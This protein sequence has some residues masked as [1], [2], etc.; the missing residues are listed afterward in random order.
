[1]ASSSWVRQ[2]ATAAI[3]RSLIRP[4][5]GRPT[6]GPKARRR[7]TF[8]AYRQRIP[9]V[10]GALRMSVVA[11]AARRRA[12]RR[13]VVAIWKP[14]SA[15]WSSCRP[16]W[17][18]EYRQHGGRR[19]AHRIGPEI[20]VVSPARTARSLRSRGLSA[21]QPRQGNCFT[22]AP[23]TNW[24]RRD[25]T[26]AD[27]QDG[28]ASH[29]AGSR[30]IK[31]TRATSDTPTVVPN[32]GQT[33]ARAQPMFNQRWG[34]G[35]SVRVTAGR[36][37]QRFRTDTRRR[38]RSCGLSFAGLFVGRPPAAAATG[39][40]RCGPRRG[41]GDRA[42]GAATHCRSVGRARLFVPARSWLRGRL[43]F[44]PLVGSVT[45]GATRY[46]RCRAWSAEPQR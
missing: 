15:S 39:R 10:A 3:H 26:A 1:M 46:R 7:A 27:F 32:R 6:R 24:K 20:P 34:R 11:A 44:G 13:V 16:L 21:A 5:S 40:H 30:I 8:P 17:S 45:L 22:V 9:R 29:R 33:G 43:L 38:Q 28:D 2:V 25:R 19:R 18:R 31:L 42:G 35:V 41:L 4:H 36:Y 12:V 23:R 14:G 37:S